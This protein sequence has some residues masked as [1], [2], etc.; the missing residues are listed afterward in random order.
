MGKSQCPNEPN[1][2]AVNGAASLYYN[3]TGDAVN[4]QM[5]KSD[6][7]VTVVVT[8]IRLL[9]ITILFLSLFLPLA[10]NQQMPTKKLCRGGAN[11]SHFSFIIFLVHFKIENTLTDNRMV[12][13]NSSALFSSLIKS[14]AIATINITE[15]WL[16]C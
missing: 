8:L 13:L 10:T 2:K 14:G 6:V 1:L 7:P 3:G 9:D 11:F 16:S 15:C 12:D 5:K 4:Q